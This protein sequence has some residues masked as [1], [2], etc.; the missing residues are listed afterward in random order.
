MH[1]RARRQL[2][3]RLETLET[4][5]TTANSGHKSEVRSHELRGHGPESPP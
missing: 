2:E 4:Q 3:A 1:D 5:A